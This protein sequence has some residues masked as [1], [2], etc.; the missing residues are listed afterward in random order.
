[1]ILLTQL[2]KPLSVFDAAPC[3][4]VKCHIL[5]AQTVLGMNVK[6]LGGFHSSPRY[7]INRPDIGLPETRDQKWPLRICPKT[8]PQ[9]KKKTSKI[10]QQNEKKVDQGLDELHKVPWTP[11]RRSGVRAPCDL[12]YSFQP[13]VLMLC[14]DV[15]TCCKESAKKIIHQWESIDCIDGLDPKGVSVTTGYT[16]EITLIYEA[17]FVQ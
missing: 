1:M 17:F 9:T 8:F 15:S 11:D 10:L 5:I 7:G 4:S 16:F 3:S 2:V 14:T 6:H 13:S 12:S